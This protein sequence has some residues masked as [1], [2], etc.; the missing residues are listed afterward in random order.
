MRRHICID[1]SYRLAN[2]NVSIVAGVHAKHFTIKISGG[3]AKET[4]R[5]AKLRLERISKKPNHEE[6]HHPCYLARV[7]EP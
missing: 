1:R 7:Q 2:D 4:S 5:T 6:A 3:S